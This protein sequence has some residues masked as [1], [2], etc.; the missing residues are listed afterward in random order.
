[1][2]LQRTLVLL[3]LLYILT[4]PCSGSAFADAPDWTREKL[5]HKQV[6]IELRGREQRVPV[7]KILGLKPRM[8]IK[9]IIL[10]IATKKGRGKFSVVLGDRVIYHEKRVPTKLTAIQIPIEQKLGRK[11]LRLL[12]S[13][14]FYIPSIAAVVAIETVVEPL[15][16]RATCLYDNDDNFTFSN[17]QAGE[18][19]GANIKALY[20]NCWK[21]SRN[22]NR[23]GEHSASLESIQAVSGGFDLYVGYCEIKKRGG[24]YRQFYNVGMIYGETKA[25]AERECADLAHMTWPG[26]GYS[27]VSDKL[28]ALW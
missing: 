11:H 13:G 20:K 6:E 4:L 25:N 2:K 10:T 15:H 19:T 26:R 12:T 22:I 9:S 1:M 23:R 27:R 5:I 24:Q 14:I 3:P 17:R 21:Q 8:V 16:Y 7:R 18:V 28:D